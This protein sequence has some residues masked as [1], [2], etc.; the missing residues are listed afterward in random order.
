LIATDKEHPVSQAPKNFISGSGESW[1]EVKDNHVVRRESGA[2]MTDRIGKKARV[3]E[4]CLLALLIVEFNQTMCEIPRRI[5]SR[6]TIRS[7]IV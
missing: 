1:L 2:E 5:D 6:T 4:M 7:A 3:R